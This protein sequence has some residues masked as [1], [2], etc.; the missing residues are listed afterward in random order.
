[1]AKRDD[2]TAAEVEALREVTKGLMQG[3]IPDHVRAKLIEKKYIDQ[4]LGGLAITAKG[5]RYLLTYKKI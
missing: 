4:K 3:V 1:M 5:R 2:L